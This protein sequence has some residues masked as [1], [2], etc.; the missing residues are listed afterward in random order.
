MRIAIGMVLILGALAVNALADGVP[1]IDPA[2][3]LT[4]LAAIGGAMLIIR[5]RRKV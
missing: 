2:S 4:A 5:G 3:G 1:E